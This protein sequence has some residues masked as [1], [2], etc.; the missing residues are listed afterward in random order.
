MT[1]NTK[2]LLDNSEEQP[3]GAGQLDG[4]LLAPSPRPHHQNPVQEQQ[5]SSEPSTPCP[6]R[7]SR[8]PLWSFQRTQLWQVRLQGD[9]LEQALL[10]WVKLTSPP[11]INL[12]VI[13]QFSSY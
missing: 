13:A 11:E 2:T 1:L 12:P 3:D 9:H 5:L 6:L 4:N 8:Q 10:D 7:C